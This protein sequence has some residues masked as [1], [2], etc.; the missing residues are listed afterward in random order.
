MGGGI[1]TMS[2]LKYRSPASPHHGN[3]HD[4]LGEEVAYWTTHELRVMQS[5]LKTQFFRLATTDDY[6]YVRTFMGRILDAITNELQQ[7]S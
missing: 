3:I 2:R 4:V 1:T 5:M 7:R 6:A